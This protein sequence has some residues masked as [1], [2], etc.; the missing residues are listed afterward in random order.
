[1]DCVGVGVAGW[2]VV[3]GGLSSFLLLLLLLAGRVQTETGRHT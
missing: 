3:A 2:V 1:M